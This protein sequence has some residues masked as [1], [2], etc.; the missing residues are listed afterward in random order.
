[1]QVTEAVVALT[2]FSP[3]FSSRRSLSSGSYTGGV[4]YAQR[5]R[6]AFH[7]FF[8]DGL[9]GSDGGRFDKITAAT[10]DGSFFFLFQSLLV[11]YCFQG[12]S[13]LLIIYLFLLFL[14]CDFFYK[15]LGA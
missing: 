10:D 14:K 4:E 5:G 1:M 15:P 7:W 8:A 6:K 2:E 13:L 12:C 3:P 11:I 9:Q